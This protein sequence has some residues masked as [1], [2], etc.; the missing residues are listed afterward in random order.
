MRKPNG[1]VT[2]AEAIARARITPRAAPPIRQRV[3]F[4]GWAR[5]SLVDRA[6]RERVIAEQSN[7]LLDYGLDLIGA[8]NAPMTNASQ[9]GFF[10]ACAVG[11]GSTAPVATQTALDSE[12]ARTVIT[13]VALATTYVDSGEKRVH[14]TTYE[15]GYDEAN[16]NLTEWGIAR[17]DTTGP[18]HVR[19]L[20]RDEHD[21]PVTLTKTTAE[22]LR[23]AYTFETTIAPITAT[24][25]SLAVTGLGTLNGYFT[26]LNGTSQQSAA[27]L[28]FDSLRSDTIGT[29]TS[30]SSA[31]GIFL[32]DITPTWGSPGTLT[33]LTPHS[34]ATTVT[35]GTYVGG[36]R[37]LVIE[38]AFWETSTGNIA[39]LRSIVGQRG[40]ATSPVIGNAWAFVWDAGDAWEKSDE[41]VLEITDLL[42]YSWDRA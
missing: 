3:G 39:G 29:T 30:G 40:G 7:M 38:E 18:V 10:R 13:H 1:V 14:T 15:F 12:I 23:I 16:G 9:T 2:P 32:R 22:K 11:T 36:S 31:T 35:R 6:G 25:A 26:M 42:T 24:A 21:T 19:E 4:S 41:Y 34:H 37:E 20:F 8:T 5:V 33:T 27:F 17:G 28:W